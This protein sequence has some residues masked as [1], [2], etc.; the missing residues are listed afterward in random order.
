MDEL[1][2]S[3]RFRMGKRFRY[4][5]CFLIFSLFIVSIQA[6]EHTLSVQVRDLVTGLPLESAEVILQPCACGGITNT[7]GRFSM[8]LP[9]D[10]YNI[11][12]TYI[13]YKSEVRTLDLNQ[14]Q[15]ITVD[16]AEEQEQLS[17][18]IVRAKNSSAQ[19][20]SLW[21]GGGRCS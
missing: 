16:L 13:G 18:V 15:T 6:Q 17:E 11:T 19:K 21:S 4:P 2:Y 7:S 8:V 20:N 10:K 1:K 5:I 9:Q 14:S 12:I 3:S